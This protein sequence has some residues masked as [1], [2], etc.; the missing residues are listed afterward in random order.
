M[1]VVRGGILS[2]Q[3]KAEVGKCD[4]PSRSNVLGNPVNKGIHRGRIGQGMGYEIS[5]ID[6]STAL[7][8]LQLAL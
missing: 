6:A 3:D 2:R 4:L 5:K 1:K 7:N 8:A